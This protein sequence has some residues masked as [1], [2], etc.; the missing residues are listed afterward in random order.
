MGWRIEIS[1]LARK[2]LSKLDKVVASR[3]VAFLHE[4]VA[5]HADPRAT[6]KP[7]K[8]ELKAYWRYRVGDWRVL[9]EVKD[10]CVTLLVLHVGHRRDVY[11]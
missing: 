4:R 9:C 6:G 5:S 1:E 2:Q 7:L 10:E 11:K 3:I 8:G